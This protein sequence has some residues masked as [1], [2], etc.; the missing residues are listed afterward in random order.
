MAAPGIRF[1]LDENVPDSVAHLLRAKGHEVYL[2]RETVPVGSP[3]PLIATV[4]EENGW[5]LV[6][7]DYDF[8]KIAPRIPKGHRTRFRK[9]SRISLQ[10]TEYQAAQRLE[11]FYDYVIIEYE[12]TRSLRDTRMFITIQSGGFKIVR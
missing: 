4:T 3:D 10:C 12:K 9:L 7:A 11:E 8:E 6:S 1:F 2:A 5:V